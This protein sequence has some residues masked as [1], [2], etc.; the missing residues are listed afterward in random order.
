MRQR[1]VIAVTVFGLTALGLYRYRRRLLSRL[2]RLPPVLYEVAVERDLRVPMHDGAELVADRYYPRS[3][4]RFPTILVRTPYGKNKGDR[5]LVM[6]LLAERGYNALVQDVRGRFDS[7]GEFGFLVGEYADGRATMEWISEQPWFD[8][9]LGLWGESYL[10]Y[11]Q[12]AAAAGAP[13]YLKAMM[14]GITG[15]R[16]YPIM[17]PDGAFGLEVALPVS[18]LLGNQQ[19]DSN[20]WFMR[21]VSHVL[22][23]F[24]IRSAFMRLPVGEADLEAAGRPLVRYREWL[25]DP[26]P[27]ASYWRERDQL[28]RVREVQA[29]VHLFGGWYD[30]F[31]R[32]LLDD[33]AALVGA[34]KNPYLTVG[35]YPHGSVRMFVDL[36]R[37]TFAWFGSRLKSETDKVRKKPV[38]LYV[39]GAN[40]WRDFDAWPPPAEEERYHLQPGA[41]LASEAP[42]S[43]APPD[44][45]RY[46]PANPTPAIGGPLFSNLASKRGVVDNRKLESRPDVLLYTTPSLR[47]DLEV[48]GP[49]RLE[50][51][52]LSSLEHTDF[53]GRLCDIHPSGKSV[54][55][56]DGLFRLEPGNVEPLP[57]GSFRIEIDMWA[58]AYRFRRGHCVRLQVSSGAHPRWNRNLGTGEPIAK[59]TA[60][61]V[62]EQAIYHDR[63]HPSAV[64]LPVTVS[65]LR[66]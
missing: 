58:T 1:T 23:P 17:H 52:A 55:V 32:Q 43:N 42:P 41:V 36:Q 61:R 6:R 66:A 51:Y 4:G 46:D 62:A 14:P 56:C 10:G 30:I 60:M 13:P 45:Y 8:G 37:E 64:V 63:E 29:D 25:S 11:A 50:L 31:L 33:F 18:V 65:A 54:N 3:S 53:F 9:S 2:L 59:D 34:G 39:M 47:S 20:F 38:R 57:D 48:I 24:R 28:S 40:E 35:P 22:L 26:E 12:W 49:V 44:R 7:D 5:P 15:S 27:D 21:M 19:V 16:F